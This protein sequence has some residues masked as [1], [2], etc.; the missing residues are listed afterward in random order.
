[1]KELLSFSILELSE[2][3]KDRSL[4]S[5]ELTKTYIERIKETDERVHA[6]LSIL[7]DDA[8]NTVEFD[9][10]YVIM[11]SSKYISWDKDDFMKK[12][13]NAFSP[14]F[15]PDMHLKK[16]GCFFLM[17]GAFLTNEAKEKK[18]S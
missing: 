4:S 3:L 8:I 16:I 5:E 11:P 7:Q 13:S 10:Y 18:R 9:D 6:Y 12:F 1:M 2:K 15:D 17:V 14:G